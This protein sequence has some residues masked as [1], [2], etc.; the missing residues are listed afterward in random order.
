MHAE[1][2]KVLGE[3]TV[4]VKY[5]DYC[6]TLKVYVVNGT[7]TNLIGL[8][9]LQHIHL[10]WNSLGPAVRTNPASILI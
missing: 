2:V 3:A 8:N 5:D 7:G 4:P 10:D 9:L 6:G 1:P